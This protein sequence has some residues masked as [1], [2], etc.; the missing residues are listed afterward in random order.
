MQRII[1]HWFSF[2]EGDELFSLPPPDVACYA[3][4]MVNRQDVPYLL[5]SPEIG[6]HQP[7]AEIVFVGTKLAIERSRPKTTTDGMN[8][9]GSMYLTQFR[10]TRPDQPRRSGTV[11]YFPLRRGSS[12][13]IQ[14][15]W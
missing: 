10:R 1:G 15:A 14:P 7:A 12:E 6:R 13:A 3:Y 9:S 8:C 5:P 2:G 11:L 4:A